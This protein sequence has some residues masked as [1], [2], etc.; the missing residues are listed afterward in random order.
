MSGRRKRR[1][2]AASLIHELQSKMAFGELGVGAKRRDDPRGGRL[3]ES[4]IG[5]EEKDDIPVRA[6]KPRVECRALPAIFL[7]YALDA[8]PIAR[9]DLARFVGRAIVNDDYFQPFPSLCQRALDCLGQKA[10]IVIVVDDN[11]DERGLSHSRSLEYDK[12]YRTIFR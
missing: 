12:K 7:E 3:L 9:D 8:R 10:C 4:V 2:L 1:Q 5:I 11:A 6:G